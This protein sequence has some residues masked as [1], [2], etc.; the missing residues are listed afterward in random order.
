VP[1]G[2]PE[3]L[4]GLDVFDDEGPSDKAYPEPD[5]NGFVGPDD[6]QGVEEVGREYEDKEGYRGRPQVLG[7]YQIKAYQR[8][9]VRRDYDRPGDLHMLIEN[10]QMGSPSSPCP[11]LKHL[12]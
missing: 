2:G 6:G 5:L 10:L 1:E 3:G 8:P 9:E 11:A 12:L 7:E 4:H